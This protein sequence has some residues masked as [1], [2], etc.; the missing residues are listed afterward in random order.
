MCLP[1]MWKILT[2]QIKE[3]IY[4]LF[5]GCGLF[6]EEQKGC[7]KKTRGT[8]DLLYIDQHIQKDMKT[9]WKI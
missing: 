5:E 2:S 7:S 1:M 3:E 9:S 4:F 8:D 6:H